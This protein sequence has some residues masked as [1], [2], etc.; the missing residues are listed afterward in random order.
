MRSAV[1]LVVYLI[2]CLATRGI[3]INKMGKLLP[4]ISITFAYIISFGL[5]IIA[6]N[7]I[8]TLTILELWAYVFLAY[9]IF[10]TIIIIKS[11]Q[12]EGIK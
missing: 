7:P 12:R 8:N 6:N 10:G 11:W 4:L 3:I 2:P 1:P 9:A 5:L